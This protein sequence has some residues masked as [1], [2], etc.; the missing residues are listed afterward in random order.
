MA[1]VKLILHIGAGWRVSAEQQLSDLQLQRQALQSLQR[2]E[3]A[4]VGQGSIVTNSSLDLM[5]TQM[6]DNMKSAAK[7]IYEQYLSE[8]VSTWKH[9]Y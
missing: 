5:Q 3:G 4:S 8:K 9:D 6:L 2:S 1:H 7:S